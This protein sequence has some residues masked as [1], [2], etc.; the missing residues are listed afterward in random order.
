MP[1][2]SNNVEP[3]NCVTAAKGATSAPSD[4]GGEP[5][6]ADVDPTHACHDHG[7]GHLYGLGPGAALTL[8][9]AFEMI[10][11]ELD[12]RLAR[13]LLN[14]STRAMLDEQMRR[15]GGFCKANGAG[16]LLDLH[17]DLASRWISSRL[18]HANFAGLPPSVSVQQKR[19]TVI[20][21]VFRTARQLG[22]DARD[23]S[24][25]IELEPRSPR[26]WRPLG[27]DETAL[28]RHVTAGVHDHRAAPATLALALAGGSV[29]EIGLVTVGDLA[30]D[31]HLVWLRGSRVNLFARWVPLDEWGQRVVERRLRAIHRSGYDDP[32]TPLTYED[33]IGPDLVL[34]PN[35]T[36]ARSRVSTRLAWLLQAAGLHL[37][38][39]VRPKSIREW[40]GMSV[41]NETGS[42][43]AVA[44]R[45]GMPDLA[46]VAELLG[47]DWRGL[48]VPKPSSR[49]MRDA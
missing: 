38:P 13:G 21:V 48:Y 42:V 45:L 27:D 41:F 7:C 16:R 33:R 19:R 5:G 37:L 15:L 29:S 31:D 9:R 17:V 18:S 6:R 39:G 25:F 46:L 24:S 35:P 23:L 47:Y 10:S 26:A 44:A 11:A 30:L 4:A 43:E 14:A 34:Q 20:S 49:E 1:S 28:L 36:V 8:E 32:G 2:P 12:A 3:A 40:L 22:L